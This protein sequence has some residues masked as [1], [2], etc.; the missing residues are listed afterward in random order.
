MN[1][2]VPLATFPPHRFQ[3]RIVERRSVAEDNSFECVA[4]IRNGTFIPLCPDSS[5]LKGGGRIHPGSI[6]L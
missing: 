3:I 1:R 6:I 4:H 5:S 2:S